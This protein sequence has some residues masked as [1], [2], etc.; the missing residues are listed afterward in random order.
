MVDRPGIEGAPSP[1][2][3]ALHGVTKVYWPGTPSEVRALDGVDLVIN[4]GDMIALTGP[5]GCGKSTLLHIL[6]L[7]DRPTTGRVT[8]AGASLLQAPKRDL[9]LL[10]NR[11]I[12]FV[13]QRHHLLP[14]LTA[15][16]NVAVTLRYRGARRREALGQAAA[17]LERVGLG[18]RL[19]H[20]PGELSGGE[21]QRVA[22]ARALVGSPALFLADEPTGELDSRNAA[23]LVQLL[24]ELNR[25]TGQTMLIATHDPRI[26][27]ACARVI[28]MRDGRIV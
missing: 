18:H 7:L 17:W 21:R 23:L 15:L 22:V 20:L 14:A 3:A 1:V 9:P 24:C 27:G 25:T 16:E 19:H 13:F 4:H 8:I 6:G 26:A 28:E 11:Y 5:S 2:A 10:R 12:G